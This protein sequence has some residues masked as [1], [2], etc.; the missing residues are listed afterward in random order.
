MPRRAV[1]GVPQVDG[2]FIV[3]AV[4]FFLLLLAGTMPRRVVVRL[5]QR[6]SDWATTHWRKAE[7]S[8]REESELWLMER[9]RRLCDD[10]RRVERLVATD[11]WMSATRQRANR[12]AYHQLVDDLRHIPDVSPTIFQTFGSWDESR[13]D[14][15]SPWLINK[16][17]SQQPPTVEVLEI[18]WRRRR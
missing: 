7:D 11:S 9:R 16:G 17:A 18:G 10:L 15:R 13:S 5:G 12:I 8:D 4:F 3:L 6:A 14:A 2:A 1:I